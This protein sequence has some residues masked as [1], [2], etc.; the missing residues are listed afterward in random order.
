[1]ARKKQSKKIIGKK[2]NNY[3]FTVIYLSLVASLF[4]I[5]M[6]LLIYV[7][8]NDG[9]TS[10]E[11]K[12]PVKVDE[13]AKSS[14]EYVELLPNANELTDNSLE[15]ISVGDEN[16]ISADMEDSTIKEADMEDVN[17]QEAN[18]DDSDLQE[19]DVEGNE[20]Q[21]ET[22]GAT[23][24]LDVMALTVGDIVPK[25]KIDYESLEQY[26]VLSDIP[27]EIFQEINGKTYQENNVIKM[28]DL[29]YL[30]L[31]HYNF[32]HEIQVGELII[33]K[34]VAGDMQHIF[35]ELFQNEY[36]IQ[37][38]YLI[39]RY[40]AGNYDDTDR[41]SIEENN[42][43]AFFYRTVS[44]T[45]KLSKHA[46]GNAIDINPQQNPYVSYKT[47]QPVWEHENANDYIDRSTG[48]AHMITENDVCYKIF[49]RYGFDWGGDWKVTKD[50]QHFE[51]K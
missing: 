23:N 7:L 20:V 45:D 48:K 4:L 29:Q 50:Y 5:T 15:Y 41:A 35:I 9:T 27:D 16:D 31:L 39:D 13:S 37:S 8:K 3:K 26:F 21:E 24:V 1:M 33:S 47:G 6:M 49:K 38:M 10:D 46:Y 30:R 11:G 51:K 17:L 36:E 12:M 18:S 14:T 22:D 44:G 42:T 25:D 32:S 43:S 28:S 2:N 40:W 34:K 19:A